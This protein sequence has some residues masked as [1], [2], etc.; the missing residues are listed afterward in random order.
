MAYDRD[1]WAGLSEELVYLTNFVDVTKPD[2]IENAIERLPESRSKLNRGA[3][4]FFEYATELDI[5]EGVV[6]IEPPRGTVVVPSGEAGKLREVPY[7]NGRLL[8]HLI[9]EDTE[10]TSRALN[11][12]PTGRLGIVMAE[13]YVKILLDKCMRLENQI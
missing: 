11:P 9:Y 6:V 10:A 8:M 1:V 4:A 2:V 5:P 13:D 12:Y 3:K 7:I